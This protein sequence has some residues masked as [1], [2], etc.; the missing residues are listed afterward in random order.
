MRILIVQRSLAP[1]GGGNAVAAWMVQALAGHHEVATLTAAPWSVDD[2][3][4]FYGTA[5]PHGVVTQHLVARPWRWLAGLPEARLTRLRMASAYG[6]SRALAASYDLIVTAEC[7]A[8]F[9]K[10]GIQY[11][12]FPAVL[13]PGPQRLP[14][15]VNAYFSLCE[16]V[17]GASWRDAAHNITLANS[18]WTAAGIERIGELSDPIVLYPPV[19]DPGDGLPWD[20]RRDTFLCVGR[21]DASKRVESAMAIVARVRERVLPHAT[22]VVVGSPVD[23]AYADR[24]RRTGARYGEWIEFRE[25][26]SRAD[27]NRLMGE[28][29][30]GIQA[31]VAEHFG[32]ATAE[33][34]RAGCLVFAHNSGGTVE[35][36]NGEPRL[37][38]STEDEAVQRIAALADDPSTIA[39]IRSQLRAHSERFSTESFARQFRELLG[40]GPKRRF[41]E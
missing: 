13:E 26:L 30:F 21:F 33:M 41:L 27:L 3:N 2:T 8:A 15:L 16:W 32:M 5:I 7:Y 29:R 9:S 20:Q 37:L 11:V 22:L 10:P 35:V 24:L 28:S 4:A 39:R 40:A 34:T 19:L 17:L 25:D 1:P 14:I 36:L 23:P 6:R 38:W 31:M 12:H 18:N